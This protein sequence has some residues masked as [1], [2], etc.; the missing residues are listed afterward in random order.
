MSEAMNDIGPAIEQLTHRLT[1][2]P[3][4][5]LLPPGGDWG[6]QQIDV[7]AIACDLLRAWGAAVPPAADLSAFARGRDVNRLSLTA[8]ATWVLYDESL[9]SRGSIRDRIWPLLIAADFDA[10]SA[11]VRA[12]DIVNDPD[13]R[14]EFA[15]RCLRAIGL[16]PAGESIAQAEDRLG[17]LDSVQRVAVVEQTRKAE[18]RA[19]K[20]REKM[21]EEA[22]KAAAARYSPE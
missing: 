2:C 18:E 17:T 13:R 16:R 20:L 6:G 8:I 22:A 3:P 10:L 12:K 7:V 1:D 14:E 21:A 15:R 9:R 19:R 4:E 5:F 11:L